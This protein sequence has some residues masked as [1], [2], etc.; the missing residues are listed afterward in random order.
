MAPTTRL[1]RVFYW[2]GAAL[3]W[4]AFPI[5][6]PTVLYFSRRVRNKPAAP[7]VRA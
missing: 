5:T 4:I 2:A 6:L 1:E 3:M 7:N